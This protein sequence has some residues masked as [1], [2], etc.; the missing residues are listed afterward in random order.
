MLKMRKHRKSR[1]QEKPWDGIW[2]ADEW[3]SKQSENRIFTLLW[4]ALIVYSIVGGGMGCLLSALTVDYHV[5]IVQAVILAASIFLAFLYYHRIWENIGYVL[6]FIVMVFT[7]YFLRNYI[8][9]GFY[10]VMND[11]AEAV[12]E[13]F[14]SNAMRSYGERVGNR[15]LAITVSMCYIGVVACL[16]INISISRRMRYL[17]SLLAVICGL[18]LP[19]Y[20]ELEPSLYFVVQLL[21]GLFMASSAHRSKHYAL[22]MDNKKYE[23]KKHRFFYI[24]SVRTMAQWGV[25]CLIM[26][27]IVAMILS[28]I[29]PKSTYHD[30]HPA[31]AFK[32][33]TEETVENLSMVGIAGL[34][35]FY[36]NVGGLTSGRLGGVSA[37]RLDYETDLTLTFV[38]ASEERFYL[39][40]FVGNEYVPVSNHWEKD[41]ALTGGMAQAMQEAYESGSPYMGRGRILVENV[42]GQSTPYLPYYSTQ[43]E[44]LT[45]IG[46]SQEYTYYTDFGSENQ[47]LEDALRWK[48]EKWW[49]YLEVPEEVQEALDQVIRDAGMGYDLDAL[50]NVSR[51]A[52]YYQAE[53]PYS[54]QPGITPYGKDFVNYFL[55]ENRKGYCAHFASAAT[56]IF[57]E[58]GIPA[59]YV[60]GYAVDP[61]DISE[62][63]EILVDEDTAQYYRGYSDLE[64]TAVV[65]VDVTDASAH[66]WVEVWVKDKGWQ[67]VDV[68]PASS[69]EEP[70]AGLWSTFMRFFSNGSNRAASQDGETAD[71]S[72]KDTAAKAEEAIRMAGMAILF[73][74]VL[75]IL[76]FVLQLLFRNLWHFMGNRGKNR[77]DVL[78]DYYQRYVHK[79]EHRIDGFGQLQSY[80]EQIPVLMEQGKISLTEDE[81][82]R[83]VSLLNQAGYSS[84]EITAE[85][86]LWVRQKL[87]KKNI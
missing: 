36:D 14:E 79:M 67:V 44:Q 34:F 62:D 42:A 63:G 50:T 13:Y 60:E 38:P 80:E 26:V 27:G 69:Q 43:W 29:M 86:N 32:K 10:G 81:R 56:L 52:E 12:S 77:N 51:L 16:V 39:R 46:R 48:A 71:D 82:K 66:A 25:C 8:N 3:L 59:R 61:E 47:P 11:L 2:S 49:K 65:R 73:I 35:N 55:T 31:G 23:R 21:W 84:M 75:V 24:Y 37:L 58:L 74:L 30:R 53:I 83:L 28:V 20:L 19:L 18:F 76:V 45:W 6:F 7:A 22:R 15:S 85:E 64:Q 9:S 72:A 17:F 78:I 54:Y 41:Q 68:T 57:R 70:G 5:V 87:K 1:L 40:Q 33:Q 4:K